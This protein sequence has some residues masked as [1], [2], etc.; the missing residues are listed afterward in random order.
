M[1]VLVEVMRVKGEVAL[2]HLHAKSPKYDLVEAF[3]VPCLAAGVAVTI[4]ADP[5]TVKTDA[6]HVAMRLSV[7]L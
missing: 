1:K 7:N 4:L 6:L 3:P 5:I 2:P